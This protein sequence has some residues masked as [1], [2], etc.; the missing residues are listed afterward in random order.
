MSTRA[1]E[2]A[3]SARV[4]GYGDL[5]KEWLNQGFDPAADGNLPYLSFD[6]VRSGTDD[7]TLGQ[8]APMGTGRLVLTVVGRAGAGTGA[9]SDHAD[10]I[11]ALFPSGERIA[12]GGKT[13]TIT[14][15]GHVMDGYKDGAY[16]RTPVVVRFVVT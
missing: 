8:D 7:D 6:L 3:L 11:A 13:I 9:L 10:A 1:V 5:P 15:P 12:A 4:A 2:N 16:W 14:A